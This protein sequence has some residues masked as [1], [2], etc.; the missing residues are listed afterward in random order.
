MYVATL[1]GSPARSATMFD[2]NLF[3]QCVQERLALWEK[4]CKDY[5]YKHKKEK[6]WIEIGEIMYQDWEIAEIVERE[7]RGKTR[8]LFLFPIIN[9]K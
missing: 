4:S 7:K 5:A 2:V 1:G 6:A 8:I 9:R 3:I